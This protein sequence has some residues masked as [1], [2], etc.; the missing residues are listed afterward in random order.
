MFCNH[1]YAVFFSKDV[2]L[3]HLT[4][5]FIKFEVVTEKSNEKEN[6]MLKTSKVEISDSIFARLKQSTTLFN[7]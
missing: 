7:F 4:L 5:W 3:L 1:S 2:Q 6:P